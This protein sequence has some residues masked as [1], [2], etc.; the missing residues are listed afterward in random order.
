VLVALLTFQL[1]LGGIG[2]TILA[3]WARL[4]LD[5]NVILTPPCIFH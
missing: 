3:P 4:A 2:W 1:L 5:V